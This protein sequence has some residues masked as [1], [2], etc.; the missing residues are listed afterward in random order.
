MNYAR[1]AL[2][3][4][5]ALALALPLRSGYCGSDAVTIDAKAQAAGHIRTELLKAVRRARQIPAYGVVLDPTQLSALVAEL[6]AARSKAAAAEAKAAL[7]RSQADRAA[8]LYRAHQTVS[9]AAMQSAQSALQVAA[10]DYAMAQAQL[11]ALQARI[12]ADWGAKLAAAVASQT[13]PLPALEQGRKLLV[14]VSLPLGE[15]L[16][17]APSRGSAVTPAGLH[18][19]LDLIGPSPRAAT[20]AAGQSLFYLM[21]ATSSAPIGTP[22]AVS[23]DAGPTQPGVIIPASAVLWH[24]RRALVYR[25]T[26]PGAFIPILVSTYTPTEGGYFVPRDGSAVLMPGT[27]IVVAGAALVLSAAESAT[28][29]RAAGKNDERD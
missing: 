16:A 8:Y 11:A 21:K 7:A 1:L 23:L 28:P 13:D 2:L 29:H 10:A 18:V 22:L 26:G 15:A 9:M 14:Q 12:R 20:G 17:T 4:V 24:D 6:A 3:L 25:Q 19:A 5:P 27:R